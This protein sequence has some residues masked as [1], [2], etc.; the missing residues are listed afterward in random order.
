M[1]VDISASVGITGKSDKSGP[2][3]RQFALTLTGLKVKREIEVIVLAADVDL[4][5][6]LPPLTEQALLFVQSDL[7]CSFKKNAETVAHALSANGMYLEAG[8]AVA[9][10]LLFTGSGVPSSN[11]YIF[12]AGN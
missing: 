9:T 12:I 5:V 6:D 1:S 8:G 10:T 4:A 2:I 3:D 7:P 11:V